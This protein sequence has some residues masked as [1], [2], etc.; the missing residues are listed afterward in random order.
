M[1]DFRYYAPT[2]VEFGRGA[3]SRTGE[4]A[5]KYGKK[6]LLVYG[7]NSVIKSGLLSR[8]EESLKNAGV[9][10]REFGG[11]QPNP[12]LAHAEEGVREAIAFGADMIIGVGGGSA[13]DTAKGIAHGAA[14]PEYKLWDI[15]TKKVA[16]LRS[17]PVGAVLTMPAAGSEMSDSAVL[18]NE[19]IG[20]KSGINTDFNRCAFAIVNP[21]LGMT[22]P[23]YQLA[24][25]VTDIMMHTMER[26]FIPDSDCDLT[27]EIAEG[28]LRTVI[29][30]GAAIVKD[31]SD[32]H[33]MSEIFWASSL[34]HNNLTECGRGKDFS[35][36]KL[37]HALSARFGAT[38]GASLA[39]VWGSWADELYKEALPRFA[40]YAR[41]VWDVSEQD[42][43]AA[44]REGIDKTV[45]FFKS[46][47]MPV[48][49]KDL[50]VEVTDDIIREL[51][52]DATMK[53][54]VKLSRIRPLDAAAV[55]K[56]YHRAL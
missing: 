32:Y 49:L 44:A 6:A 51:S 37:G 15:W 25:G 40:R 29:K 18:T 10:Y 27:D 5:A 42:D 43:S 35:V 21:E 28:L 14:N 46:I 38:H 12:T 4:V 20:K 23:K 53:D 1:K 34:S 52:L 26:Y 24:A 2:D 30:N 36:H 13:I 47:G 48:S 39:A 33:A 31:P 22:L 9:E 17:L 54:T 8:V 55:E 19:E 41:K 50:N 16:L 7:K 11:A 56:I 3:E 45:D